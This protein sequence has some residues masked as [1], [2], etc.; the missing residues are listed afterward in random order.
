LQEK[1]YLFDIGDGDAAAHVLKI[2]TVK[3]DSYAA[4]LK[5]V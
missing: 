2:G 3:D 4:S 1:Y 5:K